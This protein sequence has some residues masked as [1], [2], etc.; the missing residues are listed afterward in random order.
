MLLNLYLNCV[1]FVANDW[2]QQAVGTLT[3][4]TTI[5]RWR[6]ENF[7]LLLFL[8]LILQQKEAKKGGGE[9]ESDGRATLSMEQLNAHTHTHQ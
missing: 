4:G 2:R 9:R 3:P 6:E 1:S 5:E 8:H 7:T